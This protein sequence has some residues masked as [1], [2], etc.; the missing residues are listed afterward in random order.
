MH[1]EEHRHVSPTQWFGNRAKIDSPRVPGGSNFRPLDR[2][3]AVADES[4]TSSLSGHPLVEGLAEIDDG[5]GALRRASRRRRRARFGLFVL[6]S[7]GRISTPS[8]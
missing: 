5:L 1:V 3:E 6:W 8:A 2:E 7:G 4:T